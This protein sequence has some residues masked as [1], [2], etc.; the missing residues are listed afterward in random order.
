MLPVTLNLAG[1]SVV[2][3]GGGA[4]GARKAATAIAAGARVTVID[5]AEIAIPG[6]AVIAEAYHCDHLTG[7]DLVFACAPAAISSRVVADARD[8]HIWVNS[9]TDP[10]SGDFTLPSVVRRGELTLAISTGGAAPAL[11]RR[12]REKLEAEFDATFAEWVRVLADV[13]DVVL[14]EVLDPTRR[15]ELLDGFADWPWL[16]RLR[17]EGADAVKA[18]MLAMVRETP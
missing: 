7:A 18:A 2:V 8:R 4:V 16:A 11:G 9:A 6:A 1:W 14:R 5:P 12:I 15:R 3:V 17:A 10:E 13:R